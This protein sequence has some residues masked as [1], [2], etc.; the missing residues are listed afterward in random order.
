M[1]SNIP[2]VVNLIDLIKKGELSR[3]AKLC[4][5]LLKK[6]EQDEVLQNS[7]G[8]IYRK[9]ERYIQAEYWTRSA[10]KKNNRFWAA[11]NNLA[12]IFH[13]SGQVERAIEK[14][15]WILKQNPSYHEGRINL[16]VTLKSV[17]NYRSLYWSTKPCC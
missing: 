2:E 11:H 4:K 6:N 15:R 12:R 7:L 10:L 5:R 14:Y 16:A 1:I 17:G 13:D 9:Q 8:I 3:A